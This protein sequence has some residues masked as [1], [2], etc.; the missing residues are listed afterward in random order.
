MARQDYLEQQDDEA[1]SD[2]ELTEARGA[3]K[4]IKGFLAL[5]REHMMAVK[6]QADEGETVRSPG[7]VGGNDHMEISEDL[8]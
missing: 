5:T 3:S 8:P 1:L 2:K 7:D 6:R 4:F